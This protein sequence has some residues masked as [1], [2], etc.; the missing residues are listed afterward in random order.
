MCARA[1]RAAQR[2]L[3]LRQ[4]ARDELTRLHHEPAELLG[5]LRRR[6]SEERLEPSGEIRRGER[7]LCDECAQPLQLERA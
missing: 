7:E 2:Q 4:L 6:Q 5:G 3:E 1:R